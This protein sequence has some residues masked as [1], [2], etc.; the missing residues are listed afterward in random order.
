M[1]ERVT[2]WCSAFSG[3]WSVDGCDHSEV[4]GTADAYGADVTREE[5]LAAVDTGICGA[6]W[7]RAGD[8]NVVNGDGFEYTCQL[9]R[10]TPTAGEVPVTEASI[11]PG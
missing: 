10:V 11:Q 2:G 3:T 5:F 4:V 1:A 6:G 8:W 9:T 7:E